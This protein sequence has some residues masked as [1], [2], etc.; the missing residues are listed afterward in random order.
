MSRLFSDTIKKLRVGKGL[1]QQALAS[2]LFVTR[3]TVA[4]WENGTRLPDAVMMSHLAEALGVDAAILLSA[5]AERDILPNVILVDD[6]KL[7]LT[8]GLPV[9]KEVIPDATVTGFTDADEAIEFAKAN[10]V[11]LAFLDIE[12][13]NTS[14]LDL[15]RSLLEIN[16]HTNVV[17]LTAYPDYSLDAWNTGACGFML[18]PI[19]AKGIREQLE[20][21]RYPFWTWGDNA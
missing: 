21:L 1:S 18:K 20:K 15:C 2:K 5:A 7:I 10:R 12:L 19:T 9:L 17:Y 13:R 8:G 6:R 11:A 16:P 14:G 4:R 3:S